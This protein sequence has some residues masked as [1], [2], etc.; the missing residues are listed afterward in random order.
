MEILPTGRNNTGWRFDIK[1]YIADFRTP[2]LKKCKY[3]KLNVLF[4]RLVGLMVMPPVKRN[5]I[6]RQFTT[7][8]SQTT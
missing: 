6:I 3:S 2:H 1:N 8:I 4:N 5:Y 7:L